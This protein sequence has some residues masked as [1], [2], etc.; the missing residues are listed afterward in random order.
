MTI[1]KDGMTVTVDAAAGTVFEGALPAV[2]AATTPPAVGAGAPGR[3]VTA[4]KVMVNLAQ[5]E[6]AEE[7][8]RRDVD[9]IGLLRAEFMLLSALGGVHPNRL[10]AQGRGD[11]FVDRMVTQLRIFARAF[12]PRP[13]IYR[14]TD[15]RTNEF[16]GLEGGEEYEPHEENPMIGLRGAYR[17]V[18]NP[19]AFRLELEVLRRVRAEHPNV[20]LMLPFVRTGS[21]LRAC[22]GF[23]D[24][25]GLSDEKDFQLWVM[26]EVPSVVYWLDEYAKLGITGV[27]IG[28]N[29]L[30]Q[31]VL[32]VDRDNETLA[33]L[34][35]ERDR[36]VTS[37]IQ[38][39]ITSCRRLGLRSSICGQA[40]SVYPEYAEM[41]VRYG[42]DSI[43]VNPDAIDEARRNIAVAEQRILLEAARRAAGED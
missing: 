35:D 7:I 31:L 30:T 29:D 14:S 23:I 37:T 36:A 12:F 22:K 8:S 42:I 5:P 3:L 40:P 17:Y 34:F 41:L 32:G 21:E 26:A 11:E 4:T 39:I 1:L 38:A 19:E 6:M 13:I 18:R 15:F 24:A 20:H 33:P 9:G 25:S 16:R 27:S 10:I 2:T 28:S 43:S